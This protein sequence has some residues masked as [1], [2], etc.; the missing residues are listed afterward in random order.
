MRSMANLAGTTSHTNLLKSKVIEKQFR[1]PK[2]RL[3]ALANRTAFY[4]T[5]AKFFHKKE[6]ICMFSIPSC[7][8][9]VQR[10]KSMLEYIALFPIQFHVIHVHTSL[11]GS[12]GSCFNSLSHFFKALF[13]GKQSET[14][15]VQHNCTSLTHLDGSGHF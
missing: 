9:G 14:I 12:D 13:R 4:T 6:F 1:P 2:K 5:T 8:Q 7:S 11:L 3:S 15:R 10:V